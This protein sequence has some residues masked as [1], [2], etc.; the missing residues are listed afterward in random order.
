MWIAAHVDVHLLNRFSVA[1][2]VQERVRR[3]GLLQR[4]NLSAQR[5]HMLSHFRRKMPFQR[6]IAERQQT[7]IRPCI[8]LRILVRLVDIQVKIRSLDR[9]RLQFQIAAW[10]ELVVGLELIGIGIAAR[11]LANPRLGFDDVVL[12]LERRGIPVHRKNQFLEVIR[13]KLGLLRCAS[14]LHHI[15]P[16]TQIRIVF[17]RLGQELNPTLQHF[18]IYF[19]IHRCF[20]HHFLR[21][22]GHLPGGN[23]I[24]RC[25]LRQ[26]LG[27]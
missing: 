8:A 9:H 1:G 16:V 14:A 22:A 20:R 5:R 3:L 11:F 25:L 7:R 15:L 4:F 10:T 17:G 23:Q 2:A 19:L 12:F 24:L 6:P 27:V 13:Q 21:L 26:H 18:G